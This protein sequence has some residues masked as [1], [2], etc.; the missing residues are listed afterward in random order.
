VLFKKERFE[1]PESGNAREAFLSGF[2]CQ[3]DNVKLAVDSL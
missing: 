1:L 2:E 3:E